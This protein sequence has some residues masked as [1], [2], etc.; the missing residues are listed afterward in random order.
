MAQFP[1][2]LLVVDS[3]RA[4]EVVAKDGDEDARDLA[5]DMDH[6]LCNQGVSVRRWVNTP[7]E[8]SR[9]R[10][11]EHN[12]NADLVIVAGGDGTFLSVARQLPR[13]TPAILG[14][15][16]G[17]VGFLTELCPGAWRDALAQALA[18]GVAVHERMALVHEVRRRGQ[19]VAKGMA[20]NDLVVAR[21]AVARL[22]VLEVAVDGERLGALRA[23]GLMA[24]TPSGSTGYAVSAGGPLMHPD[25]DAWCLT[26][27]C[28]FLDTFYPLVLPGK[29]HA[30]ITVLPCRGEVWLTV[31]G[32][33][34]HALTPGD[35]VR[36][37]GDPAAL[38]FA[39]LDGAS[40]LRRLKA[41]GFLHRNLDPGLDLGWS[42]TSCDAPPGDEDPHAPA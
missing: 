36:V 15:N 16:L 32:Q 28:S 1:S 5:E 18:V 7:G 35:V 21:G 38:R 42:D 17:K 30:E 40:Y 37:H 27:I 9:H 26:P 24:S 33:E 19:T 23:D 34:G 4:V 20:V 3:I 6:W 13:P 41:K 12:F 39:T 2:S 8:A 10:A 14:F 25:V 29:S 31:D 11:V 22:A